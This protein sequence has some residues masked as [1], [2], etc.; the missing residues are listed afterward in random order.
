MISLMAEPIDHDEL[1]REAEAVLRD[2]RIALA[3]SEHTGERMMV[4]W[5]RYTRTMDNILR[6]LG[7][8]LPPPSVRPRPRHRC[9]DCPRDY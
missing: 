2:N 7:V 4:A 3:R 1:M 5:D 6:R 9:R 8:E